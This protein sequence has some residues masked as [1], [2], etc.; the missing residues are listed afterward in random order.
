MDL[1]A[2]M[3]IAMPGMG[4]ER[5][6]HSVIYICAHSAEGAM[7]LIV[8]KPLPDLR[9]NDLVAQLEIGDGRCLRDVQ[10]HFGGPVEPGRGFVL[11]SGDYRSDI[12]TLEVDTHVGMTATLDILEALAAGEGPEL[13]LMA[14]GYAGW[15]P[16]QLEAEIL[17]NGWLTCEADEALLFGPQ[18]KDKWSEALKSLGVDPITLSAAAGR[19]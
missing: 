13:A 7:G 19:A 14:L 9:L 18:G 16:G 2:K 10:V 17:S 12:S 1:T 11:H 5:F 15:G 4:D 8:N 6:G 3:L